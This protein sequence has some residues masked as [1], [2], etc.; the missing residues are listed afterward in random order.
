MTPQTEVPVDQASTTAA[1]VPATAPSPKSGFKSSEFSATVVSAIALGSGY[2]PPHYT[3]LVTALV[4]V[5]V[6]SR[7]LLK[8][9]H[10]LGYARSVP[11]LPDVSNLKGLPK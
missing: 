9:V 6:A 11:D 1:T 5:Y 3:P 7:T 4:G 10:A 2:I 8:A